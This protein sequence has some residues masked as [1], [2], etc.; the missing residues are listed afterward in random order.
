MAS[1][2]LAIS[3]LAL[4]LLGD[5]P[6]SSLTE[7]SLK[8]EVCAANYENALRTALARG[9]WSF[10]IRKITLELLVTVPLNEWQYA[11]KLPPSVCRVVR[12][13]P[14]SPYD[15]YG[16]SI[17]SNHSSLSVDVVD[18]LGYG[19]LSF[20]STNSGTWAAG[21]AYSA[22]PFAVNSPVNQVGCADWVSIPVPAYAGYPVAAATLAMTSTVLSNGGSPYLI[23]FQNADTA[24]VITGTDVTTWS[25]VTSSIAVGKPSAIGVVSTNVLA[26]ISTVFRR[27]G[28][29]SG[30]RIAVRLTPNLAAAAEYT[31]FNDTLGAT[32][33][34]NIFQGETLGV[35]LYI[36]PHFERYVAHELLTLIANPLS[37]DEA[38]V[39]N[40]ENWRQQYLGQA[41][42]IDA[43]QRPNKI[44][45]SSAFIDV[46]RGSR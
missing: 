25:S 21:G 24:N 30:N 28:W 11:Y 35:E 16:D 22:T 31:V 40:A 3:N 42:A 34:L 23:E 12:V 39:K 10:A 45:R 5:K 9:P 43:Q 27:I 13:Y 44:F 2:K 26:S 17:Y 1:S 14:D 33:T 46:R 29:V 19:D 8:S 18:R 7:V 20:S 37:G 38:A 32:L 41:L 36:P 15:I 6:L 4:T